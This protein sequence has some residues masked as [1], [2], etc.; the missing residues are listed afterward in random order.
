MYY[1]CINEINCK[2]VKINFNRS[3]YDEGVFV[4]P[5]YVTKHRNRVYFVRTHLSFWSI[6]RFFKLYKNDSINVPKKTYLQFSSYLYTEFT[7]TIKTVKIRA[8]CNEK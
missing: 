5:F 8:F 4:F 1:W 7:I 3:G 2:W 6:E